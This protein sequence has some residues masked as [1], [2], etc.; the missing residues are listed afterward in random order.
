[1]TLII[2]IVKIGKIKYEQ[3]PELASKLVEVYSP[4]IKSCVIGTA[5]ELPP[6]AYDTYRKQ[7]RSDMIIEWFQHRVTSE[8]IK[9]LI[10]GADLYA[11]PLNFVFGQAQYPSRIALIS[12]C[13][14][15]PKYYGKPYSHDVL[16]NRTV[17]EAA[18]ELGHAFGLHH[19]PNPTCV[20][21]FSD[22]INEVDEKYSIF[23]KEC[24]RKLKHN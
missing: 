16:L 5:L 9:L 13:R 23:C 15:D 12:I 19:C 10:T 6:I 8:N 17:K 22:N 7:Y 20:M 11:P 21:S 1:M 3:L 4:L 24:L 18:H 14:L 2:E